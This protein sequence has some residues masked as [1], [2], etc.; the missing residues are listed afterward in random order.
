MDIQQNINFRINEEFKKNE[1][2]FV[3][4][5]HISMAPPPPARD[6]KA[7]GKE[8]KGDPDDLSNP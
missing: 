7:E 3:T 8:I 6:E 4:G 2:Y 1:I 5:F